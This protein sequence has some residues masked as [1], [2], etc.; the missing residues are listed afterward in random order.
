MDRGR[1]ATAE[2]GMECQ[3]RGRPVGGAAVRRLRAHRHLL[4]R[5]EGHRVQRTLSHGAH[6]APHTSRPLY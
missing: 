1:R 5:H 3:G 4:P 6:A 2:E